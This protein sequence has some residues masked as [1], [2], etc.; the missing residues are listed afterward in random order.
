MSST[1]E[2]KNEYKI[3]GEIKGKG[4]PRTNF[5]SKRIY[6]PIT[7]KRYERLIK[8]QYQKANGAISQKDI[9]IRIIANFKIPKSYTKKKIKEIEEGKLRPHKIDV[10]NIAKV[11]M[12]ALNKVA[13]EDDRQIVNLEVSK[14]YTKEEENL[15]IFITEL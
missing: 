15:Q 10:D 3:I 13:Y 5:Y 9:S 14:R 2:R 4:R 11:V 1:L 8:E 12:D 6:T 7:T